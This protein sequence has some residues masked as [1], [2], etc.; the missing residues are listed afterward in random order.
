MDRLEG[1]IDENGKVLRINF[2]SDLGS[3][4]RN[5][6]S[7]T[8]VPTYLILDEKGMETWRGTTIPSIETMR[9]LGW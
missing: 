5:K 3:H 7:V 1:K 8:V 6:Y 4:I 9:K 2:Q